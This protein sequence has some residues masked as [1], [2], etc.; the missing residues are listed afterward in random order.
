MRTSMLI[1]AIS[2]V[3]GCDSSGSFAGG[4]PRATSS[5]ANSSGSV[6]SPNT[7]GKDATTSNSGNPLQGTCF[8]QP[9][10]QAAPN[11]L[12]ERGVFVNMGPVSCVTSKIFVNDVLVGWQC[13]IS[14]RYH[15]YP[16]NLTQPS[17]Y[18]GWN[19]PLA[20]GTNTVAS[21]TCPGLDHFYRFDKNTKGVMLHLWSLPTPASSLFQGAGSNTI[22]VSWYS[23]GDNCAEYSWRNSAQAG[24]RTL[25]DDTSSVSGSFPVGTLVGEKTATF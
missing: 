5:G 10:C 1:T 17:P 13:G 6:A 7:A 9:I 11:E 3:C 19:V 23:T 18:W 20:G 24:G 21:G 25:F 15:G 22:K 2:F 8:G 12:T 16:A 14:E 4:T